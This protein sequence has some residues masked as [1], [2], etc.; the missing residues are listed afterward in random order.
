MKTIHLNTNIELHNNNYDMIT[1]SLNYVTYLQ[2]VN[3]LKEAANDFGVSVDEMR[4]MCVDHFMNAQELIA[5][6]I[7]DGTGHLTLK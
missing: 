1:D 7:N 4:Q 5:A 2:D 6:A 3:L